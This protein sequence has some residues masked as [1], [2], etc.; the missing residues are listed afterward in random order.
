MTCS[1][2]LERVQGFSLQDVWSIHYAMLLQFGKEMPR[3]G[4]GFW[5]E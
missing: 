4:A 2:S 5:V 3:N 1:D